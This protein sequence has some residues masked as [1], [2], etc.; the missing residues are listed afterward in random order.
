MSSSSFQASSSEKAEIPSAAT[1]GACVC[2]GLRA[3]FPGEAQA[4]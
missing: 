1:A 3:L 2:A 4:D